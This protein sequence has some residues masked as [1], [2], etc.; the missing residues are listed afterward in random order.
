MA[1]NAA[2]ALVAFDAGVNHGAGN[3]TGNDT[4]SL[5]ERIKA[6]MPRARTVLESGD[7]WALVS[8]WADAS[9]RVADAAE[10]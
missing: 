7:A 5:S 8:R 1:V 6:A 3:S 4:G 10:N 9:N 2:A